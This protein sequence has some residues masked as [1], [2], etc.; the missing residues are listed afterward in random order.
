MAAAVEKGDLNEFTTDVDSPPRFR[1]NDTPFPEQ[2]KAVIRTEF[3]ELQ[4]AVVKGKPLNWVFHK[5]TEAA[6]S[7]PRWEITH[8]ES[9]EGCIE[10][11]YTSMF[12]RK[13]EDF[14]IHVTKGA[15]DDE[16]VV[17]MRTRAR[18]SGGLDGNERITGFLNELREEL[19]D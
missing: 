17:N 4:P 6:H 7:M 16:V 15:A 12:M 13:K 10:G 9:S 14:T 1:K 2:F 8:Q 11:T 19:E 18:T 3:P 5:A